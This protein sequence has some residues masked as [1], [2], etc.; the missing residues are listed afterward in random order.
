MKNIA[1]EKSGKGNSVVLMNRDD[2][3]KEMETLMSDTAKFQK[4]TISESK[5]Y[6]FMAKEKKI[7]W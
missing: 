2:Y 7:N 4:L 6:N 1:I 3:I 5:D